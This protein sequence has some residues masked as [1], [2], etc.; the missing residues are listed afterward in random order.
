MFDSKSQQN[1]EIGRNGKKV[2]IYVCG[3][4]PYDYAH[5]GHAFTYLTFDLV[6]RALNFIGRETN[7]VQNITDIDAPLFERSRNIGTI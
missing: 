2:Q 3:I 7:Y 1:N 5:L 6:I 4:T